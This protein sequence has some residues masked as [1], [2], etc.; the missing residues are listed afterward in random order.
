M[1]SQISESHMTNLEE[2]QP[3]KNTCF[4]IHPMRVFYFESMQIDAEKCKFL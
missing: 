2:K 3:Q 1:L 4:L